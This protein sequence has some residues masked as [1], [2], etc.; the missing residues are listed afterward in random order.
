MAQRGSSRR[1]G[2]DRRYSGNDSRYSGN[3]SRN[4]GNY[5]S[6][7][8]RHQGPGGGREPY[9]L[10]SSG[11]RARSMFM[12]SPAEVTVVLRLDQG[13]AWL[14]ELLAALDRQESPY[15]KEILAVDTDSRDRTPLILRSRGIR[16]LHV[17]LGVP[18]RDQALAVAEGE[19]V[20]F[21]DQDSLPLDDG[22]LYE[23]VTPLFEEEDMVISQ[24]RT[25]ADAAVPPYQ[26]GLITASPHLSGH[27]RLTL[28]SWE[29][30]QPCLPLLGTNLGLS[31]KK[32]SR[33]K[34]SADDNRTLLQ[35]VQQRGGTRAYIPD[36]P[37][38]MRSGCLSANELLV[39]AHTTHSGKPTCSALADEGRVLAREL[40]SLNRSGDL[41]SGE[42]GEAY[43]VAIALRATRAINIV[44]S[45]SSLLRRAALLA[46]P[47]AR[48]WLS[49]DTT[50][51]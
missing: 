32:L 8:Y 25:I 43:A 24:G 6:G 3:D 22:W 18:Y 35:S 26:R 27:L 42:R 2:R 10:G 15:Q 7:A 9:S 36:S 33:W 31:R 37:V 41:P 4:S 51:P 23:L 49:S 47:V 19:V 45:G 5:P 38:V 44:I 30:G 12:R 28:A 1:R 11:N 34:L 50:A 48:R 46:R 21:L 29:Q 20:V 16:T 17:P 13:E 40:V 14:E 39:A